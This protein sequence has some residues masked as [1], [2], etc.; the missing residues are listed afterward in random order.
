[1][2]EQPMLSLPF[3]GNLAKELQASL[4]TPAQSTLIQVVIGPRQVGKTTGVGIV[5]KQLRDYHVHSVNA[6]G[7]LMRHSSWITEHWAIANTLKSPALLVID[8]IQ[9]VENWSETIKALWDAQKSKNQKNVTVVLLGSSSLMIQQGLSESLAGRYFLHRVHHWNFSESHKGYGLDF[10]QF[11]TYGGYPGSY[12]FIKDRAQWLNYVKSSIIEPVIAKDILQQ[13][14]VKSPALFKQCFDLVCCYPAQEIS[15]NKLLGQ[16]QDRGN[17]DLV[18]HYLELFEGA[19]LIRQIF[20][21]SGSKLATKGSSPKILPLCPALFSVT[22]DA[23]LDSTERGRVFELAV[24]AELTRLPGSLFYWRDANC[25]LDY[26]YQF[27]KKLFAIEVKS[28]RKGEARKM[29]GLDA[30]C[31]HYPKAEALVVTPE[32]YGSVLEKLRS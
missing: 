17:I 5:L 2:S 25:E 12:P 23:E 8:E 11:L 13:A 29:A 27:G 20:K 28:G 21:Y 19:L 18:K 9:K 26:V 16:L 30:F 32:N 14:R 3:V 1:M 10:E 22:V 24:G 4:S 6:D 31:K 7:E 15:Y